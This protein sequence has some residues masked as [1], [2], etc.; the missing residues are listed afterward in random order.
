VLWTRNVR[1]LAPAPRGDRVAL[2]GWLRDDGA[3]E[4][5][6]D[7]NAIWL[8]TTNWGRT[9]DRSIGL[10]NT[11]MSTNGALTLKQYTLCE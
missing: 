5:G 11:S 4:I 9:T 3:P 6:R 8:K 10:S 1:Y 7:A 2:G